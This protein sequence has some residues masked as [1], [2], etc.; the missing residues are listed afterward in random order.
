MPALSEINQIGKRE[1][2]SDILVV[3]DAK[4]TPVT[5]MMKKGKKPVKT[6]FDW[7]VGSVPNPDTASVPDG[8]PVTSTEDLSGSRALLHNRVHKL[9]RAFGVSEF[10]EDVADPAGVQSEFKH[11]KANALLAVKRGIE[12]VFC[13]DQDS[14][15]SGTTHT[16]RGL[17]SWISS[18]AQ[19]DNPVPAAY[20]T[21][22]GSIKSVALTSL[23]E[24]DILALM[25]SIYEQTGQ[26]GDW[27]GIFGTALKATVSSWTIHDPNVSN[28]TVVRTFQT[29]LK[30][31]TL[32]GTIDIIKGDFG[33][34]REHP[35]LWNAYNNSTKAA[36]TKRGY[37]LD[38]DDLMMRVNKAPG[39][40][41]LPDD[42]SGPRGLISAIV[43]DQMG[44]PLKHGKIVG[45]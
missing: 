39:F 7:P 15:L 14:S 12:A 34:I 24:S 1:D 23:L 6:I 16:C 33:T 35:T 26:M 32:S 10:A 11:N 29:Q 13:G 17:G 40:K 45:S 27:D 42:D 36:D 9:R 8:A 2:L 30:D 18:S 31:N 19:T 21:P 22:A 37:V 44:S 43:S 5:S 41:P 28:K 38:M 4:N 3:A 20:R 25:Q